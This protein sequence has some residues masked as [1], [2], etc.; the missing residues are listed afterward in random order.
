MNVIVIQRGKQMEA[1]KINKND[2]ETTIILLFMGPK[3][4]NSLVTAFFISNLWKNNKSKKKWR[5]ASAWKNMANCV[6]M[7]GRFG[8]IKIYKISKEWRTA[9]ACQKYNK[10]SRDG[11]LLSYDKIKQIIKEWRAPSAW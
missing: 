5:A 6:G 1:T 7:A 10:F 3:Y 4:E 2:G 11:G 8:I 9:S